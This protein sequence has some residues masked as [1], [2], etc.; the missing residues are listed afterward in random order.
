MDNETVEDFAKYRLSK[1]KETVNTAEMIFN[2]LNDYSS[3]NN[4]A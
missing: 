2:Q 4:R 3:A 1:A